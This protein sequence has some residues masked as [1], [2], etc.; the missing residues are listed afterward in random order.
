VGATEAGKE[1]EEETGGSNGTGA[2]EEKKRAVIMTQK[3][4]LLLQLQLICC[5]TLSTI[6]SILKKPSCFFQN[7]VSG[8]GF[9]PRLQVKPTQLGPIDRV[10]SYLLCFERNRTVF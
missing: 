3:T 5:W 7:N 1:K 10:S 2:E 4:E 9:C 8:T 6:L